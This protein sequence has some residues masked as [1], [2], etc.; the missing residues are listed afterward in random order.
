MIIIC[1]CCDKRFEVDESLIPEKGR[2]LKCGSCDQTWFY[3]RNNQV[4]TGS[5]DIAPKS[6]KDN[7]KQTITTSKKIEKKESENVSKI[8]LN[9]GSEIIEYQPTLSFTFSK[10]LSYIIV[11]IISFVGLLIILDTFKSPFYA[12]FPNLEYLLFSLYET[13]KDIELFVKDL[14]I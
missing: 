1:P 3:N 13:L 7:E 10:F 9:K 6:K 14:L 11:T 4:K 5:V 12:L 8:P 2:L